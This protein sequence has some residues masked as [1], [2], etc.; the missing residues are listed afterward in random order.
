[1]I[2]SGPVMPREIDESIE[3]EIDFWIEQKHQAEEI[4]LELIEEDME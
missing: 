4:Q 2:P 3:N 1:M